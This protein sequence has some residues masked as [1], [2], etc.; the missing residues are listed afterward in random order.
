MSRPN[1]PSIYTANGEGLKLEVACYF[2]HIISETGRAAI[3]QYCLKE[4]AKIPEARDLLNFL[5]DVE[6]GKREIRSKT[7]TD[8]EDA[9][10]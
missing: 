2:A 4:A 1:D 10:T 3:R 9:A 8:S 6:R 7:A 5:N